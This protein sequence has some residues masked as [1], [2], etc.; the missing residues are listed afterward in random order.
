VPS[1][2]DHAG[3]CAWP[4]EETTNNKKPRAREIKERARL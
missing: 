1:S 2:Q 4:T 3:A